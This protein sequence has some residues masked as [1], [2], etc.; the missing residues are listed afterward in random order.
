M[1]DQNL[2]GSWYV[3]TLEAGALTARSGTF[4]NAT[5]ATDAAIASS[6]LMN[7]IQCEY[8]QMDGA[9]HSNTTGDGVPIYVCDKTYGTTIK[10]VTALCPDVGASGDPAW[11]TTVDVY[12]F[13]DSAGTSATILSAP[14]YITESKTDYEI[15]NGT[16]AVTAMALGD[17]LMAKV[18]VAGANGTAHQGLLVQVEVDE[19]GT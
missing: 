19:Q 9:N 16:L 7:R 2:M 17:V 6:K 15:C 10:K 1:A 14:V 5:I 13:D 12:M 3:Q 4:G 11:N 8:A 18:S